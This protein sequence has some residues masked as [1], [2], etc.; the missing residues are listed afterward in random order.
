MVPRLF[1][2][3]E[4]V[5]LAERNVLIIEPDGAFAAE[6]RGALE[7]YGF[8]TEVLPDGNEVLQRARDPMPDLVLLCV[9]PKNVGYAI[10]NKLKKNNAW[11]STPIVL[12]SAEA[13][14]DTFEQHRKLKTHAD[15]YLIKP[16]PI[17]DLLSKVD[18]LIGLGDLVAQAVSED[19]MEI[20]IDNVEAIE[21]IALEDDEMAIVE[22]NTRQDEVRAAVPAAQ[23]AFTSEEP[24]TIT[25]DQD[26]DAESAAAFASLAQG[27]D[28]MPAAA[29]VPSAQQLAAYEPMRE[30]QPDPNIKVRGRALSQS[31]KEFEQRATAAPEPARHVPI[32]VGLDQVAQKRQ[33][34]DAYIRE[35]QDR[36]RAVEEER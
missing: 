27:S 5:P 29:A 12:M 1:G 35:L 25:L 14:H 34:D 11:K 31:L 13:T 30:P 20:P 23:E 21:E 2:T 22:E 15:E 32:D 4:R 19:A 16:F 26:L 18:E 3:A 6:L 10:C 9:E 36:V 33:Q 7:P 28:A 24:T 8:G 17:E